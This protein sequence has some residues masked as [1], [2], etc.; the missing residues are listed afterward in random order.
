MS[1]N[2]F[3]LSGI[4]KRHALFVANGSTK[5]E[6]TITGRR[7]LKDRTEESVRD[8]VMFSHDMTSH[9]VSLKVDEKKIHFLKSIR[10]HK[11]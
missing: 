3:L 7:V 2:G 8:I 4:I 6:G 1:L 9:F 10:R 11:G 5:S